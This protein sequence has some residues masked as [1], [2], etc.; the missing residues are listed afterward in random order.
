[1]RMTANRAVDKLD[2][3]VRDYLR[4]DYVA[5]QSD[6][7][8]ADA[9][10]HLRQE[11]LGE[12]V[13]YFYVIDADGRLVGVLPT[14]R[15]LMAAA[16]TRLATIMHSGV[17]SIPESASLMLACEFFVMHRLLAFPVVDAAGRLL[18]IVDV[19]LFTDELFDYSER[20]TA[21]DRFQLIGVRLAQEQTTPWGGFARRFPWLLCNVAGGTACAVIAGR[22]EVFLD[23]VIVLALFIPVVLALAESVSMQ[24]VTLTLQALHRQ[25]PSFRTVA[26]SLAREFVTATLLG[27][28]TGLLVGLLVALWKGKWLIA[29]SVGGTV[30]ISMVTACLLGVL[31]PTGVRVVRG[32]PRIA[33]GPVVLAVADVATL[34]LYFN[35]A[36][37]LLAQA[38]P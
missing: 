4:R 6:Q 22:Y 28:G 17:I 37:L 10:G 1:M 19:G 34:I 35:L 27:L 7:T 32:D 29:A 14:R 31:L 18:G 9:L 26:R 24:S 13:V 15:L 23:S 20:Q 21:D 3:P 5:L 38:K 25:N 11:N 16:D 36:G 12:R 8:V 2:R 33:A 30:A